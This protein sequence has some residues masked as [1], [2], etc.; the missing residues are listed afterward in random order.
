M[1]IKTIDFFTTIS[2]IHNTITIQIRSSLLRTNFALFRVS[3][4]T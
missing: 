3:I 2:C 4:K 1:T